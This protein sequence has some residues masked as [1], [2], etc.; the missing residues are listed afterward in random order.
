MSAESEVRYCPVEV[1]YHEG[2]I[3]MGGC[4]RTNNLEKLVCP[5]ECEGPKEV[6]R[7]QF[8]PLRLLYGPSKV[9]CGLDQAPEL[10]Q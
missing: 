5:V 3:I 7:A 6:D 1:A 4:G 9:I 10:P 8:S 2:S